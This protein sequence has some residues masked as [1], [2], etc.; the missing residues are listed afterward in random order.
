MAKSVKKSGAAPKAAAT[1]RKSAENNPTEK[2]TV[3]SANGNGS[4]N[5][6]GS[7]LPHDQV[8][9][10]A[11]RFWNERGRVDGHHEEDWYRAEQELRARAS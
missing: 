3:A 1:P 6:N 9:Q 11:H 2:K 7:S 10:L 5:R 4:T 8:A